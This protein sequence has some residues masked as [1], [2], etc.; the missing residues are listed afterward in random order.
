MIATISRAYNRADFRFPF[1]LFG[2]SDADSKA[3]STPPMRL[4]D[5]ISGDRPMSQRVSEAFVNHLPNPFEARA[6][7]ALMDHPGSTNVELSHA[8][9]WISMAWQT[10]MLVACLSRKADLWPEGL[11]AEIEASYV[12]SSVVC[13][14]PATMQFRMRDD[15]VGFFELLMDALERSQPERFARFTGRRE[16]VPVARRS[17][18]RLPPARLS[19]QPGF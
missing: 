5:G 10:H 12:L 2:Q 4:S 18:I 11:P 17:I 9:G 16:T 1:R 3:I 14:D 19:E 7:R 15:V 8:C 6:I 13:Y